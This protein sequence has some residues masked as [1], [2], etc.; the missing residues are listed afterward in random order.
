MW[1]SDRKRW[2]VF[3]S[4][5]AN[6][7]LVTFILHKTTKTSHYLVRW[8][9][10]GGWVGAWCYTSALYYVGRQSIRYKPKDVSKKDILDF[11]QNTEMLKEGIDNCASKA[12]YM[13]SH[14]TGYPSLYLPYHHW[15]TD[16]GLFN[17]WYFGSCR[18]PCSKFLSFINADNTKGIEA[19]K[20]AYKNL[21]KG[22]MNC[23]K[24]LYTHCESFPLGQR[25]LV[26]GLFVIKTGPEIPGHYFCG[27]KLKDGLLFYD[28][29]GDF[30]RDVIVELSPKGSRGQDEKITLLEKRKVI[31]CFAGFLIMPVV[32]SADGNYP[33]VRVV[34]ETHFQ[35]MR[36]LRTHI[37]GVVNCKNK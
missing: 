11:C 8:G 36:T 1:G 3:T 25:F 20:E 23:A 37:N 16:S 4:P 21:D 19:Y 13:E 7:G 2:D 26:G 24:D 6:F 18:Y 32:G 14:F 12:C 35:W 33:F 28:R 31:E 22:M 27:I 10:L 5:H 9:L 29:S 30:D 15:I 34:R 17:E